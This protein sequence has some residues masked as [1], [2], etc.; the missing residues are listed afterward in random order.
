M[1]N[2]IYLNL[3]INSY[4]YNIRRVSLQ[5]SISL[6]TRSAIAKRI[7]GTFAAH[8]KFLRVTLDKAFFLWGHYGA[9]VT[10]A[11]N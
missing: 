10:Y 3:C 4:Y 2:I 9:V 7:A 1:S 6:S 5:S 11:A 8:R